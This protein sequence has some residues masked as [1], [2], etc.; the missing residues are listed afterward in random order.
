M[1]IIKCTNNWYVCK[2]IGLNVIIYNIVRFLIG[3]LYTVYSI[4]VYLII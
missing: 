4:N 1:S 3:N 2:Y